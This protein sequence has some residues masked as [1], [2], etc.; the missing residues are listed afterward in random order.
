[1]ACAMWQLILAGAVGGIVGLLFGAVMTWP[2][3]QPGE[4]AHT[5]RKSE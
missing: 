4:G 3:R 5:E 1:M 2:K